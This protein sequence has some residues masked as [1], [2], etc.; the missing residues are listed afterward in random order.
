MALIMEKVTRDSTFI[1]KAL[2]HI[3]RGIYPDTMPNLWPASNLIHLTILVR[4][5]NE[6]FLFWLKQQ[7]EFV[8]NRL[9]PHSKFSKSTHRILL[10]QRRCFQRRG[11]HTNGGRLAI[12]WNIQQDQL[13]DEHL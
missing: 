5:C 10:N 4:T 9:L 7:R 11:L 2:V 13:Q 1:P 6:F 12:T 8:Y 3:L